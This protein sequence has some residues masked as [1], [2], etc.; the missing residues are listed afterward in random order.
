MYL[1]GFFKT[2]M[3]FH[4]TYSTVPSTI[5]PTGVIAFPAYL[6]RDSDGPLSNHHIL[7]F[8]IVPL[9]KGKGFRSYPLSITQIDT[10]STKL[11]SLD[12][13]GYAIS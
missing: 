10:C 4:Y 12:S 11:L 2:Y 13:F 6:S 8:D 5:S 7:K 9:N 1:C 3:N